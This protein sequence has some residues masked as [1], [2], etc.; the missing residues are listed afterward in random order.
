MFNNKSKKIDSEACLCCGSSDFIFTPIIWDELADDWQLS[1]SER[2]YI[3]I[4]Q[5]QICVICGC[6][7]R[8]IT[9]AG[10]IMYQY[11]FKGLFKDFVNKFGHLKILEINEAGQLNQFFK[12]MPNHVLAEY[13][14]IS[15]LNLPYKKEKFDL[16]VHS[17]TLEHIEDPIAA[18]METR[19]VLKKGG[20]TCYTVP[21]I[22]DR[23][24]KSRK[25]LKASFHGSP[26]HD[27]YRVYREY[28][29]DYWREIVESGYTVFSI[30]TYK[31]PAGIAM[32][33]FK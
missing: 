12:E 24:T 32:V 5:G 20:K 4:Q 8:S 2:E 33:G 18:L 23:L 25:G 3:N 26:G 9:L 17:D 7:V 10:A 29:A 19:R 11:G 27:E 16:V 28:G 14:K 22:M 31:F 13:P 21:V 1:P 15:I 6:N 30:F